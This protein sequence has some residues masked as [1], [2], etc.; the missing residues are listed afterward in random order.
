MTLM[1]PYRELR[2]RR[3]D[4][5]ARLFFGGP[6]QP[7]RLRDLLEE[8]IDG[9]PAGGQI[10]WVTYY[11]RDERLADA[12]LRAHRRGVSVSV[13]LEGRPR[14][15]SANDAVIRRLGSIKDG[16]GAGLRVVRR[17]GVGHVHEKIYCFSHPRAVALVGSFNPSGNVPEDPRVVR[18]INDQDRGHNFLVELGGPEATALIDHARW[19]HERGPRAWDRFRA[20][21]NRPARTGTTET[22]F[23]PRRDNPFDALLRDV[24]PGTR[25]RIAASHIN[26]RRIVARL[27]TLAASGVRV[28]LVAEATVRRVPR[29]IERMIRE[30][31]MRFQRYVHPLSLPMHDKFVLA[32]GPGGRWVAFGSYNLTWSS[33]WLNHEVLIV[34]HD[35][36]LFDGFAAR[37]DEVAVEMSTR[38]PAA[39]G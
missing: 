9:V 32:D 35:E 20:L 19:M 27:Q 18:A 25:L 34:T 38:T 21:H 12:L 8:R 15:R 26:D 29:R 22:Y 11:F 7:R 16:I 23:L 3:S 33:R 37:W 24:A 1:A 31:G 13:V 30:A 28:E 39:A 10:S 4:I 17:L 5:D 36:E 6:D 2:Q 14:Y